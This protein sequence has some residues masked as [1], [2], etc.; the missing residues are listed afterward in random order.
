MDL[1][2]VQ[3]QVKRINFMQDLLDKISEAANLESF[4]K[5]ELQAFLIS[6]NEKPSGTK[7]DIIDRIKALR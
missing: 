1:S 5:A 6:S 4:D 3:Q 7:T 2:K